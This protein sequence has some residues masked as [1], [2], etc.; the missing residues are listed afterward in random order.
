MYP[1]YLSPIAAARE[2]YIGLVEAMWPYKDQYAEQI[3]ATAA[4]YG[5]IDI[6]T[7]MLYPYSMWASVPAAAAAGGHWYILE[8]AIMRECITDSRTPAMAAKRGALDMIRWLREVGCPL[9]ELTCEYAAVNGHTVVLRYL[10]GV[11][12]LRPSSWVIPEV[13][14]DTIAYLRGHGESVRVA[15]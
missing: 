12:C 8:M 15:R 14:T 7:R 9:D 3:C 11:G 5:H 1:G 6:V 13:H 2:G 10:F 4:L